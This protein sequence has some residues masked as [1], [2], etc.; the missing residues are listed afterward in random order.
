MPETDERPLA[1]MRGITKRYG[2]VAAIEN[3]DFTVLPGEVH[4]LAGENGAGKSTLIKVLAGVAGTHEGTVESNGSVAVIYQELSLV[5]AMSV[6]D[7]LLLGRHPA[8]TGWL[9][10][11]AI[12][13]EAKRLLQLVGLDVPP[14]RLVESLPIGQQQLIEIA[15]A[16]GR[17]SKLIVM[18]EPTSAL[19]VVEVNQLFALIAELK[20]QGCGIVY[21]TH[22]MEEIYRIGDR[23][24]VLRDGRLVGTKPI[25]EL[26]APRL[27]E[28][29][30]GREIN[31]QFPPRNPALGSERLRLESFSVSG[32]VRNVNLAVRA[33][34]I[35][36]IAGLQ[37]SGASELLMGLFGCASVSGQRLLDGTP[38]EL[39]SPREAI[40]KGLAL[41]TNDRKTTGLVLSMSIVDNATLASMRA[42]WRDSKSERARASDATAT[43]RLRAASLDMEAGDLSGGNQQKVVLAK[44]MLAQ[45]SVLLLDEP[46]RGVDVGAKREIYDWIF[47]WAK[48]GAAILLISTELP[49]LLALSDRVMVLHRG[50]VMCILDR[51]EAT[52][53]RVL[54]AAMGDAA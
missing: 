19:S 17:R 50:E 23:I 48:K 37:G 15:K 41:V 51:S 44:W 30:V 39:N 27:I 46:T 9:R 22:K 18:D 28:W 45:P 21:I 8:R 43:L 12:R 6:A 29:M 54:A 49:E 16:I 52:P 14:E 34:E 32:S 1:R 20:E 11:G 53:E 31:Q 7:N 5:P 25:S 10:A 42:P 47:D 3:V 2:S 13:S 35:V 24:T 33:G 40:A 26:P 4:I 36:G 38:L